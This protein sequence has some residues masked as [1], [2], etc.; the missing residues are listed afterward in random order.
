MALITTVEAAR[1]LGVTRPR[2]HQFISEGRLPAT[3]FGRDLAIEEADLEKLER[4]PVGHP[5]KVEPD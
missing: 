3:R 4:R 5:P 2:I 1:R